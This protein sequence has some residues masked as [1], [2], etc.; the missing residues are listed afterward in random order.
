MVERSGGLVNSMLVS[1]NRWA[2]GFG[3]T[4]STYDRTQQQD[5]EVELQTA[6]D[7]A[8]GSRLIRITIR[9]GLG[10]GDVLRVG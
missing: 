4:G 6:E 9:V 3:P 8:T 5:L 7:F 2:Q 1:K 10:E